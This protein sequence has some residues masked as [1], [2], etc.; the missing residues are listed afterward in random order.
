MEE[1]AYSLSSVMC[2]RK[3]SRLRT[4]SQQDY[5]MERRSTTPTILHLE[6]ARVGGMRGGLLLIPLSLFIVGL[7][8]GQMLDKVLTN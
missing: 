6:E 5:E 7:Y 3:S 8:I 2:R 4:Y 1:V